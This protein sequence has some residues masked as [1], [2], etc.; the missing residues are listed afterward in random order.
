MSRN[1]VR[2][3]LLLAGLSLALL[4]LATSGQAATRSPIISHPAA[5]RHGLERD[6]FTQIQL[7]RNRARV[8][9]VLIG[10]DNVYVQT[11]QA[12]LHAIDRATGQSRWVAHTGNRNHPS[13]GMSADRD[14]VAT[15]NGSSLFI[16]NRYTGKLLWKKQLDGAPGGG[17]ALSEDWVFVPMINGLVLAY[18]LQPTLDPLI[19]LG[20]LE[21]LDLE[22]NAAAAEAERR[23]SLRLR[24]DDAPK[25]A[26]QSFGRIFVQ[27]TI[28][29]ENEGEVMVAWPT[30]RGFLFVARLDRRSEDAFALKYQLET[31]AGIAAA[32]AYLPPDPDDP[33][34]TGIVF[35]ASRDG[36]LHA[37][38]EKDGTALWR[39][40]TSEPIVE[41]PVVLEGRVYFTTQP[42][43]L[44]SLDAQTGAELWWAPQITKFVAASPAR[45]YAA[46]KL[47]RLLI[48]DRKT[49]ARLDS[50]DLALVPIKVTNALTDRIYLATETGL[51]Q[52]LHEIELSEPVRHSGRAKAAEPQQTKPK[53]PDAGG[54]GEKEPEEPD[55]D[56]P[57]ATGDQQDGEAEEPADDAPAD[58]NPFGQ[59]DDNPFATG[60]E[61]PF[62]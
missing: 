22:E 31:D 44:Y 38:R 35:T 9:Q 6:W 50:L 8:T 32:P 46:D 49:G 25:L 27:P 26:C 14:F 2:L 1:T 37:L 18:R 47:G 59:A 15:V 17:P 54:A 19:E 24:Q 43:G 60:D 61:N 52:C 56:N 36:V 13:L 7:D 16:L 48:L 53:K 34:D 12:A 42:G 23:E 41:S 40:P 57:F 55:F 45:V 4:S 29:R 30:D 51:V 39:F 62:D 20:K 11:D 58:D 5:N 28:L 10:K 33:A 21:D 3:P